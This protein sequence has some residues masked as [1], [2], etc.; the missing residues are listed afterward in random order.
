MGFFDDLQNCIEFSFFL[1][2]SV[3]DKIICPISQNLTRQ[4]KKVEKDENTLFGQFNL[5]SNSFYMKGK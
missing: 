1:F 5:D 2:F 3:F 4:R